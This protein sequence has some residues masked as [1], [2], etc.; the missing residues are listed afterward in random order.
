MAEAF[1]QLRFLGYDI[2][3][4]IETPLHWFNC[5]FRP[6]FWVIFSYRV[7]RFFYL[8]LGNIWTVCRIILAPLLFLLQPWTG[9]CEISYR[10]SIG[11]GLKILHPRLG[12][13]I[14][15]Y[16]IIGDHLTMVG[17]NCIGV[18]AT[19]TFQIGD[20][21]IGDNLIMGANAVIVGPITVGSNVQLGAGGVLVKNTPDNQVMVGVPARPVTKQDEGA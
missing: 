8:A 18:Q 12:I 11:K 14:S 15:Q 4:M 5:W 20:I 16:A 9:S 21:R 13:V 1:Q 19:G 10:A 17:G 7:N 2:R 3:L 6:A